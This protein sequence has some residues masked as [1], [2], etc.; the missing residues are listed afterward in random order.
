MGAFKY[1]KQNF[2]NSYKIRS[3]DYRK[4]LTEWRKQP[5]A[6]RVENPTNPVRARELGYKARIDFIIVRVR[7][8]RG[9]RTRPRPDL[10]RKPAKNRLKE[11]PSKP[12]RWLAEKKAQAKFRNLSLVNSYWVGEDGTNQYFEVVMRDETNH[13]PKKPSVKSQAS[14]QQKPNA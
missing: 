2:E 12:W 1:I 7:T 13:D 10:G 9:K 3:Q 8:K 6:V 5:T 4:R 14:S 11:N